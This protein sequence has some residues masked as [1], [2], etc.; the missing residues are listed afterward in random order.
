MV[1]NCDVKPLGGDT[2]KLSYD[3][4]EVPTYGILKLLFTTWQTE[5]KV[6]I[7]FDNFLET[8]TAEKE[9]QSNMINEILKQQDWSNTGDPVTKEY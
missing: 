8:E 5:N 4:T 2:T 3:I 6:E 7:H 1:S 9:S